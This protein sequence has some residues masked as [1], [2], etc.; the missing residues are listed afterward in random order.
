MKRILLLGSCLLLWASLAQAVTLV[1]TSDPGFYNNNIGT[2]LNLSN[3]Q[4]DNE[5]QP[6]P[7]LN[8]SSSSFSTA[9]DLSSAGSVLGNWLSDPLNLNSNWT[10]ETSIPSFWTPGT[11]VAIIYQFDT[12]AAT[13]VVANFGV[14]NGLFAWLDGEYIFGARAGGSYVAG[15][16]SLNLGDFD[17]GTHFLQ[18]LLE[19][20]GGSNGYLVEI[21]ADQFTPGP[22]PAAVPEPATMLLLGT[23]LIG[24]A[25]AGRRFR[26]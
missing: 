4:P 21:T 17:A 23:G 6:F 5:F 24:L 3:G 14:D 16:Y 7:V 12:L 19:D 9:P 26:A 8:D 13:N 2:V 15:E 22:P 25:G 1:E 11:E 20:H 18:L 10:Y